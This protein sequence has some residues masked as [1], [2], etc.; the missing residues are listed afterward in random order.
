MQEGE[1]DSRKRHERA[2]ELQGKTQRG[3][4][5]RIAKLGDLKRP[6]AI[7]CDSPQA[8]PISGR[9]ISKRQ[10]TGQSHA[11]QL[12]AFQSIDPPCWGEAPQ[13]TLTPHPPAAVIAIVPVQGHV[14][15]TSTRGVFQTGQEQLWLCEML[16]AQAPATLQWRL[17]LT[18]WRSPDTRIVLLSVSFKSL[19]Q[20]SSCIAERRLKVNCAAAEAKPPS[21]FECRGHRS[22]GVRG[23]TWLLL[24]QT[25]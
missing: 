2:K 15:L 23:A 4:V 7:S 25:L 11:K 16:N 6:G 9:S 13:C 19:S 5:G 20:R 14:S 3:S 22:A 17:S 18:Q 12:D 21:L 24:G 10:R 8:P 1:R